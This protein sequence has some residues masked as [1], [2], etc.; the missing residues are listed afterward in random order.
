MYALPA[1]SGEVAVVHDYSLE[2][3]VGSSGPKL[4]RFGLPVDQ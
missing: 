4:K 1:S 2:D 3:Y